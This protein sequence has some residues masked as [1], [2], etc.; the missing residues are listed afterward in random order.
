MTAADLTAKGYRF[1]GHGVCASRICKARI[2]WYSTP[3]GKLIPL[4]TDTLKPHVIR[5]LDQR[6]RQHRR[7]AQSEP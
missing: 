7:R 3:A 1:R 6:W 2:D 4:D 5:S